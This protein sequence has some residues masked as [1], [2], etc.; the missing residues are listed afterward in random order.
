M[1][2]RS[3]VESLKWVN[4]NSFSKKANEEVPYNYE[5]GS[6]MLIRHLNYFAFEDRFRIVNSG[7]AVVDT[8]HLEPN[9]LDPTTQ[10][11]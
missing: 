10:Q 2:G 6:C 5:P 9:L 11:P 8:R 4:Y 3:R 7:Y 1:S